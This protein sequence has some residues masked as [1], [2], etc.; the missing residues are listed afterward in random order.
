M[1]KLVADERVADQVAEGQLSAVEGAGDC[2]DGLAEGLGLEEEGEAGVYG[3]GRAPEVLVE[4]VFKVEEPAG[5]FNL[6]A[7][8]AFVLGV[9]EFAHLAASAGE[10]AWV[11][12]TLSGAFFGGAGGEDEVAV[13]G[14]FGDERVGQLVL[15]GVLEEV[16]ACAAARDG[17]VRGGVD[18]VGLRGDGHCGWFGGLFDVVAEAGGALWVAEF[19]EGF[20]FDLSDAFAGDGEFASDFFEGS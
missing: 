5:F 16:D 6:L 19:A 18:W 9:E 14:C 8:V 15:D 3:G 2:G 11:A 13:V 1:V 17:L 20:G 12:G 4:G 7:Q 10:W